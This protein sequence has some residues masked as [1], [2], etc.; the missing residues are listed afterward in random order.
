ME[1]T[2]GE[3]GG[4]LTFCWEKKTSTYFEKLSFF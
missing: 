1:N 4:A 3:N 2:S